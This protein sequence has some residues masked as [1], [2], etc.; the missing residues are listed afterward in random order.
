MKNP[1]VSIII[2]VKPGGA[3][4]ALDRLRNVEYPEN[5]FEVLVAEGTSPSRQRNRAA[6]E[7]L[8]EI[9]YFLDDDSLVSPD[10]LQQLVHLYAD[11]RVAVAGGPSLTP[12]ND[13]PLCQ[14]FGLALASPFGAGSVRNRY[15]RHGVCRETGDNE[16]I[17]CNLSFSAAAFTAAGGFDE[18]LYPNEE[19]ELL[20]RLRRSGW[21]LL[22]DPELAVFRSQRPTFRAFVRQLFGY[23]RGRGQQIL[24]GGGSGIASFVPVF[25]LLYLLILPFLSHPVY[26][27]P[28]L[29]Y[30]VM[31]IYGAFHAAI[32][33]GK[34]VPAMFLPLLFPA[35]HLS[36]GA[37][38][39]YGLVVYG[40]GKKMR[41]AGAVTVKRIKSFDSG[42][43]W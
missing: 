16:L 41:P 18:R 25:F 5:L 17:L 23:G 7:A 39:L 20:V 26:Y 14:A 42:R 32:A 13:P 8:G 11:D 24:L 21:K 2:P 30:L 33:S 29:C 9:L 35:L 15:R 22:H 37:G 31:V 34:T 36:Y 27:L 4:R 28:L 10:F 40:A 43:Y 6:D 19:N 38:L 12:E 1:A 3:V